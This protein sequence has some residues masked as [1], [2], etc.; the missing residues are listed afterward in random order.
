MRGKT[1]IENSAGLSGSITK[2][3]AQDSYVLLVDDQPIVAEAIRRMLADQDDIVFHYCRES[4]KAVDTAIECKPTVILQ[5]LVMPDTDGMTLLSQYRATSSTQAIPVIVLST[6]ED[7]AIKKDAFER[8]ASD[9]LVKIPDKIELIA[10]IHAHSR[11]Y[12]AHKQRDEAI[13]ELKKLQGQLEKKNAELARLSAYDGLTDILNRR[14]FDELLQKEWRRS[15]RDGTPISLLLIDIDHFKLFNDNYGHQGGDKCLKK[16]AKKLDDT[17]Y[18]S[19]DF[20]ARYGGEEFA[21]VLPGTALAGAAEIAGKLCAGV[22]EL[23]ITHEFS[24]VANCVTISVGVSV[25]YPSDKNKPNQIIEAADKA[26]YLAKEG[27]RNQFKVYA[28]SNTKQLGA[29]RT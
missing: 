2:S 14:S 26:L 7:P 10:R 13:V 17:I 1:V 20:V 9:Y 15:T 8:G 29:C 4:D 11:S 6:K 12:L 18:R 28:E 19:A 27:G 21:V 5:D 16:V 23:H 24:S 3:I 22:E 25:I